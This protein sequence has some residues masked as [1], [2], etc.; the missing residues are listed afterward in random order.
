MDTARLTRSAITAGVLATLCAWAGPLG[1]VLSVAAGCL[2][3]MLL[4]RRAST[5]PPAEAAKADKQGFLPWFVCC[6][7]FAAFVFVLAPLVEFPAITVALLLFSPLFGT[8]VLL[9]ESAV[10]GMIGRGRDGNDSA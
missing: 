7:L 8:M 4:P 6:G 10:A 2:A 1:A 5:E 3:L 9:I